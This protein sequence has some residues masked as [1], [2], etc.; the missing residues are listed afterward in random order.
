MK[1]F[2]SW[3]GTPYEPRGKKKGK[4]GG[5]DCSHSTNIGYSNAGFPYYYSTALD[6]PK[7]PR[8]KQLQ[9][10]EPQIG[11]VARWPDHLAVFAGNGMI[12]TAHRP[13]GGAYSLDKLSDWTK[14]KG[15]T[16]VW[17]RYDKPN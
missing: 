6:F 17:Y 5:T 7:N 4:T 9:N 11:D 15:T 3:V 8:F 14:S 12:Y 16:P 1:E 2:Q 13:G 10:I